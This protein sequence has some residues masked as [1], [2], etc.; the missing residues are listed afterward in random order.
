MSVYYINNVVNFYNNLKINL[1]RFLLVMFFVFL[2]NFNIVYDDFFEM[3]SKS[4]GINVDLE[5]SG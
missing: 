1:V 2:I 5:K 3:E 4:N